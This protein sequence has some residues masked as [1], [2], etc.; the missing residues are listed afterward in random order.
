M[1]MT[2]PFEIKTVELCGNCH[3]TGKDSSGCKCHVCEGSGRVWKTRKGTVEI[4]PYKG[5]AL[6][7][8]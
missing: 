8:K 6:W 7:Q 5:Q 3:G 4:E 1:I 2:T